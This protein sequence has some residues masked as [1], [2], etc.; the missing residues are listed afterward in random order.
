MADKTLWDSFGEWA[1]H[2]RETG[3]AGA[4]QEQ[5]DPVDMEQASDLQRFVRQ[6]IEFLYVQPALLAVARAP[7]KRAGALP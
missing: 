2:I 7:R 5:W 3:N 4:H 1:T 6:L